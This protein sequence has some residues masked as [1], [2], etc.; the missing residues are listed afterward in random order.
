MPRL[1]CPRR[2][3]LLASITPT[4]GCQRNF[5]GHFECEVGRVRHVVADAKSASIKREVP[6]HL[7]LIPIYGETERQL[8]WHLVAFDVEHAH[9]VKPIAGMLDVCAEHGRWVC[10]SIEK[11]NNLHLKWRFET[12]RLNR[13][14][15]LGL[16]ITC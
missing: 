10:G 7:C 11:A 5:N 9:G 14:K 8:Q 4:D 3:F 13:S 12:L 16:Q 15:R 1:G 2:G 6:T